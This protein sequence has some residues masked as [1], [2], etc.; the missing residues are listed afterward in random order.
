MEVVIVYKGALAYYLISRI[1]ADVY[2]ALLK[3]YGGFEAPPQYITLVRGLRHWSGS[4]ENDELLYE[5][6][7]AID[8]NLHIDP[9]FPQ[10]GDDNAIMDNL[11]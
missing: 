2:N 6:G 10:R 11:V 3:H 5:L 7:K 1:R 8:R 4:I 9:L